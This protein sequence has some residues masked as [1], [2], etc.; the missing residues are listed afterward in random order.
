MSYYL[1]L[2][3]INKRVIQHIVLKYIARNINH[4][5][6]CCADVELDGYINM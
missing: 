3:D 6:V 5:C 2:A 4:T 1:G